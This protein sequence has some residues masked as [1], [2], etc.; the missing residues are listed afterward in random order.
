MSDEKKEDTNLLWLCGVIV[1]D[2]PVVQM[3]KNGSPWLSVTIKTT[4]K[5]GSESFHR[6]KAFGECAE[7]VSDFK[8]GERLALKCKMQSGKYEKDGKTI[9][10][11]EPHIFEVIEPKPVE[12]KKQETP[13]DSLP[14]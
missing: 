12:K 4:G 10:T 1:S 6:C 14:F 11:Y 3:S 5:K 13:G 7:L 8:K 9:Y 2:D